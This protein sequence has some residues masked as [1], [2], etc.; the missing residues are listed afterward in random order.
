MRAGGASSLESA[1]LDLR[2][3]ETLAQQETPVHRR[4]PRAKV[5]TALAFI[6]VVISFGKYDVSA[7]LPLLAYPVAL[8]VAGNLPA[9]FVLGKLLLALPFALVIGMFNPLLDRTALVQLGDLRVSGGWVSFASIML[10]FGLTVSAAVILIATT[11]FGPVCLALNRLKAPRVF[12]T[13]L[14]LLYRYLF[15]LTEEAGRMMRAWSLRAVSERRISIRVFGSLAGQLLLRALDRAQ[16]L[17]AAMLC[18]GFDGTIRPMRRL[19]FT[20]ADLGFV[21][22]WCAFFMIARI[23]HLPHLLGQGMMRMLP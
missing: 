19:K 10:R 17:H 2:G 8:I 13:Q 11:G 12:T 18:R 9:R 4:D 15:V 1:L 22:G 20:A 21:A 3:I 16:R 6:A 14:M 23:Y 5:V 7:L